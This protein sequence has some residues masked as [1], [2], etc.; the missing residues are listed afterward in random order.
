MCTSDK[1]ARHEGQRGSVMIMTA[2][3]AVGL[4]LAV[5]LAIDISRI[6]MI[7]TER[8]N[9]ADAAAVT[10]ARELNGGSGG[11]DNAVTKASAVL[12][13]QG[14]NKAGVTISSVEFAVNLDD[15]TYMDQ[16]TARTT[17]NA[18]NVHFVRV[19]TTAS[20][21]PILFALQALGTTRTEASQA[22]A[23][24]SVD[25]SGICDFYPAAIG[26]ADPSPTPGTLMTLKFAQGTG[27]TATIN[28][29]DYIVLD[30]NC[31]PGNG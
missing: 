11:I 18:P 20:S 31:I 10:A 22:V 15:A 27:S 25:L 5:G 17:A 9:A 6:Y 24:Q 7:R 30:V 8:Q 28:D 1:E 21:T 2:I 13:T 3:L 12:N 16:A 23:G 14:F 26:L 29:K 4:L 19:T